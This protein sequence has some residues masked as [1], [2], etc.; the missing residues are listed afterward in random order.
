MAHP[1][2]LEG[3]TAI[4]TGASRGIGRGIARVFSESGANLVLV[5][6]TQQALDRVAD[7]LDP[8]RTV[9]VAGDVTSAE[10]LERAIETARK[11][12]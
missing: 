8:D 4:I 3:R 11:R 5:S 2:S 9:A 12:S 10:D 6:R 7:Q 1:V